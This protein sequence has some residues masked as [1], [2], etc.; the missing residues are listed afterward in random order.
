MEQEE[1][2]E[3]Q[4]VKMTKPHYDPTLI[5]MRKGFEQAEKLR[6]QMIKRQSN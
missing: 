4:N 5:R 3:E 6:A 1:H 2:E